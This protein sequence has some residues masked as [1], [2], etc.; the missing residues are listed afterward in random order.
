M[1]VR[2][3][4]GWRERVAE[5]K[6]ARTKK[7]RVLQRILNGQTLMKSF[8]N[9]IEIQECQQQSSAHYNTIDTL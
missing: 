6:A 9:N 2:A 5:D 3:L 4:E 8:Y 1:V 7:A